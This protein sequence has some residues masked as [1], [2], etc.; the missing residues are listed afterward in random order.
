MK[1][2]TLPW[3]SQQRWRTSRVLSVGMA[4]SWLLLFIFL[5]PTISLW[6]VRD[7][8]DITRILLAIVGLYLLPGIAVLSVLWRDV[9]LRW[10]ERLAVALGVGIALPPFLLEVAQLLGLP[11]T[12]WTT[13]AYI[14]ISGAINLL[15]M[16]RSGG[17]SQLAR[18]EPL[19]HALVLAY[20]LGIALVIRLFTVRALPVGMWGDSYHHTMI[21][22]LLVD[23]RGLFSSWEPYAP[24]VTFTYHFGFHANVAFFHML[25][26]IPVPQSVLEVG[27]I[28]NLASLP[29]AYICTTRL[30]RNRVAGLWAA[31]LTGFINTQPAYY[32]NWGRYTQ[33][34][35]HVLLPIVV[36]GWMMAIEAPGYSWRRIFFAALITAC[37]FLTHYL[38]TVF[39]ALFVAS[40]LLVAI[41]CRPTWPMLKRTARCSVLILGVALVLVAPWLINLFTGY[42]PSIAGSFL[43]KGD[44]AQRVRELSALPS[45]TPFFLKGGILVLACTAIVLAA[46]RR[47]WT[48]LLLGLWSLL[49]VLAAE[50][51]VLGLPGTGLINSFTVSIALYLTVIPL[52]AYVIGIVVVALD[53]RRR[54]LG[55][56]LSTAGL[57]AATLWGARW[58]S[59]MLN[60]TNQ[61]FTPA[62]AEAMA[63]VRTRTPSNSFFLVNMFPAYGDTLVAGSDGGWWIPLLAGRRTT[64][65]PITY[66]SE[67]AANANYRRQINAF[68]A[69]LRSNPLPSAEGIALARA[70]GINYI[71][72]GAH[73]GQEAP[74]NCA[75]MR[76]HPA[77]KVVYDRDGVT[78]LALRPT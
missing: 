72:C 3:N 41:M 25:T 46:L 4:L 16:W 32:V 29:A 11:W 78:I 77:F 34:T 23:H 51:H 18:R 37:L 42:L 33:L 28:V 7:A 10:S 59:D 67:R 9:T 54:R 68:A 75:A 56:R 43:S 21:A 73:V 49:L 63:W 44:S 15:Q 14:T 57:L 24:L 19:Q 69:K 65:P 58:Q 64:L 17:A 50:P 31:G 22:Q 30:T 20:L 13:L 45:V 38:V 48:V 5:N 27:Q 52:A 6:I 2:Q 61:L 71:Y 70:A 36:L 66:G 40:Y 8:V 53:G 62:D 74:L 26:A 60:P 76:S 35:G 12:G 1:V 55:S 47:K 39:A